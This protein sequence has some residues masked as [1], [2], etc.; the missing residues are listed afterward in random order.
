MK[1]DPYYRP[2]RLKMLCVGVLNFE[3]TN[4][5]LKNE[6]ES[7]IIYPRRVNIYSLLL[8]RSET[9]LTGMCPDAGLAVLLQLRRLDGRIRQ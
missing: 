6:G 5:I 7:A 9:E 8:R 1:K 3:P 4:I 2:C